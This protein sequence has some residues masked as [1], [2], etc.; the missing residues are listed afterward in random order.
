[1]QWEQSIRKSDQG[2]SGRDKQ[3]K[4]HGWSLEVRGDK[5]LG[6]AGPW[7]CLDVRR[8]RQAQSLCVS[9]S[10]GLSA[11]WE[12]ALGCT[13]MAI[14]A[15]LRKNGLL[16]TW[17]THMIVLGMHMLLRT[18]TKLKEK[19]NIYSCWFLVVWSVV[20]SDNQELTRG[21]AFYLA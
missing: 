19:Y 16:L 10:C 12:K 13:S 2:G 7:A 4:F 14:V 20:D 9:C 11:E 3:Q 1:M 15:Q 8:A 18:P 6:G 5:N 21:H 17:M